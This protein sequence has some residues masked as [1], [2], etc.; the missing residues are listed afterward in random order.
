[1]LSTKFVCI[2]PRIPLS[3]FLAFDLDFYT[4][5]L[6][7][8]YLLEHLSDKPFFRQYKALNQ[9]LIGLIEDYSLVSFIPLNVQVS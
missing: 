2:V 4:E 5:V 1:M 9:A 6:D 3:K 7:L 8:N